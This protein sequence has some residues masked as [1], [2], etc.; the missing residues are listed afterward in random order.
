MDQDPTLFTSLEWVLLAMAG[1]IAFILFA[2]VHRAEPGS[3]FAER[4]ENWFRE[5][6]SAPER[7]S[8][9]N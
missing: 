1:L 9:Q 6:P 8:K 5:E 3:P 2:V 4:D 7:S